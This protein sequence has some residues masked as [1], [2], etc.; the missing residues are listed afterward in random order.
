MI[1]KTLVHFHD[2]AL[3]LLFIAKSLAA[4]LKEMGETLF[5]ENRHPYVIT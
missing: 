3:E 4:D 1:T 2:V 5:L